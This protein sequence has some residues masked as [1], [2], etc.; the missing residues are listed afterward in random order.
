MIKYV[1]FMA[2]LSLF[3]SEAAYAETADPLHLAG[4]YHCSGHDARDGGYQNATVTLTLNAEQSDF[5]ANYGAYAFTLTL[6]DGAKYIGEAAA[7]GNSLAIYFKNSVLTAT[8]RSDQG[9]GIAVVTHDK[10]MVGKATTVFHKFYYEPKYK[11]GNNGTE[12]CVKVD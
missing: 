10:N 5:T 2:S 12:T 9:V 3:L 11:G 8:G 4:T 6:E 7:S 1:F